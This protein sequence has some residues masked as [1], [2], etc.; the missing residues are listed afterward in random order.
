MEIKRQR[1]KKTRKKCYVSKHYKDRKKARKQQNE[2]ERLIKV[3]MHVC[4]EKRSCCVAHVT[5]QILRTRSLVGQLEDDTLMRER[6]R[7]RERLFSC[8]L[9]LSFKVRAPCVYSKHGW[10]LLF[11]LASFFGKIATSTR[12]RR[13]RKSY[14]DRITSDKTRGSGNASL[15]AVACESAS[16]KT[17]RRLAGL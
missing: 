1:R 11:R 14:D 16:L 15:P 2:R 4:R 7:E 8:K 9:S 5:T 10:T 12:E 13:R 17:G 3:C 6:E